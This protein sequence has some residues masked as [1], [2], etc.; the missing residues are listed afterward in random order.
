MLLWLVWEIP[1]A[2]Y[3][4]LLVFSLFWGVV[5]VS[6][7][8]RSG[9]VLGWYWFLS[10]P[11]SPVVFLV[12]VYVCT[13]APARLFCTRTKKCTPRPISLFIEYTQPRAYPDPTGMVSGVYLGGFPGGGGQT[14]RILKTW[15]IFFQNFR[16][17]REFWKIQV[18]HPIVSYSENF[19]RVLT[20]LTCRATKIQ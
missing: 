20:S 6:W 4:G 1:T 9:V 19:A 18:W 5:I 3:G 2:A 17:W 10:T 13:L 14:F 8:I 7:G 11:S 15:P 16:V 12:K